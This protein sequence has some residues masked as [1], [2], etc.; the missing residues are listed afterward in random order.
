MTIEKKLREE[1]RKVTGYDPYDRNRRRETVESRALYIHLLCKY[2]KRK[3]YHI[4]KIMNRNH[5]TIL[6]SLKNFDIYIHYNSELEGWLY[7]ILMNEKKGKIGM[8]KE[9]IK[10]KVDYLLDEDVIELSNQVRDMYEEKLIQDAKWIEEEE[11]R[12]QESSLDMSYGG[13]H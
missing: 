12:L 7:E 6:H 2:H 10:I 4:A 8:R 13:E 3:P 11:K 5:A 1:V 9:F